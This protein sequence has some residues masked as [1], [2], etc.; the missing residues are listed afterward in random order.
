MVKREEVLAE[1]LRYLKDANYAFTTVT[2]TTHA[3]VVARE[4]SGLPMLRDIFG[5]NRP[6][7]PGHV[8]PELLVLL[9]AADALERSEDRL[10]SR[11]RVASLGPDL[12]LHS[13]FPT[14]AADAVF[15][16]PDTFRF[17][18]F[19]AERLPEFRRAGWLVDMGAGS[20]AG[21][22]AA[23]R[24]SDFAK[25]TMVDINP[26]ALNLATVNALAAG[27]RAEPLLSDSVPA[28]ADLI[29]ANPPYMIDPDAR[30]YRDGG[31]L[32]G[33]AVAL[34]WVQQALTAL[35]PGG[36]M[37]LY[38]GAAYV[39]G[40]APLLRSLAEECTRAGAALELTEIDPD[41]FGDELKK[42]GYGAV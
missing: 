37:L 38:T 34:G 4:L 19:I 10:R 18:R 1:L 33:G 31:A 8:A 22:V 39:S 25:A 16:G 7:A 14:S 27:I 12:L 11:L 15:F 9:E 17:A 6:F 20:G 2:P 42:P 24:A 32:F 36:S 21:T 23:L 35:A 3:I 13:A 28:G 40:E 30:A 41:V 29:I 26:A 5:W